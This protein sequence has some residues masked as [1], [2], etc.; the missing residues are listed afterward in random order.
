M[1]F[2][3]ADTKIEGLKLITLKPIPDDRGWFLKTFHA[4]SFA[5]AGLCTAFP[6]SFVS[7]SKRNVIRAMHFQTP[8]H[9]HA[10][11][12]R[13]QAGEILDVVLDLRTGSATCREHQ[14]FTLDG[15]NP[16]CLY[17]PVGLAHGLLQ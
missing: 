11:L 3:F 1:Q 8:P 10:K 2:N 14:A 17:V 16:Q 12:M 15:R 7:L 4:P 6:E 5:A 13:C 9:D